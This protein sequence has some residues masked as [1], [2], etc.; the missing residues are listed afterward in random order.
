[1]KCG[2]PIIFNRG[3]VTIYDLEYFNGNWTVLQILDVN[4]VGTISELANGSIFYIEI[5]TGNDYF[6]GNNYIDIIYA[7]PGND[8]VEGYGGNDFISGDAG[9]D[10]LFGDD[11]KDSLF[12]GGG[13]D[14]IDGLKQND[15]LW[16]GS[17]FDFFVYGK[18]YGK[19]VIKDLNIFDDGVFVDKV[20]VKNYKKLKKLAEKYKGGVE[21]EF[22]KKEILKIE[23]IKM[24]DLKKIDFDFFHF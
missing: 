6:G 1:M 2:L 5:N 3:Y 10:N 13:N 8:T 16:G 14:L 18:N 9:D 12:G 20:L 11:G 23:G 24:K 22:S 17:G 7:G 15:K 21:I 19:D 4:L